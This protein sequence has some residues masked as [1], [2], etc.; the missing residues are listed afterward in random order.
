MT[1]ESAI[2]DGAVTTGRDGKS[3]I[4][5]ANFNGGSTALTGTAEAGDTVSVSLNGGTA[6]AAAVASDGTWSL[7]LNGLTDG[8]AYSA[9]A[10][11]TDAAGNTAQS[12]AFGFTVDT[13]TSESAISDSA[14]TTGTDGKSYINA[15]NF[16]NGSTTL[17]GQAEAGDTVSVSVNGGAAQAATV[18]A[19]GAWSLFLAGL[20][21]D[22]HEFYGA[23]ATAT[24]P[25][26]NTATSA[27]FGFAL[28]T[29]TSESAIADGAVTRPGRD[30]KS[31]INGA[32]FNGGSTALTGTAEAGDTVSVSLSGGTAQA[33]AVASDGTWSLTL[34]GLTDGTAYSAV[35]TATDA[36]GNTA[37]SPAF[38]FTVDTTTSESAIADFG[39]VTTGTDGKSYLNAAN[40]NGGT[41]FLTGQMEPG[42]IATVSVNINGSPSFVPATGTVQG[43]WQATLTG[44][45]DGESVSAVATASDV[46]GNTASSAPLTFTVDTTTS[47]SAIADGAVT[48]GRDGKSYINGANFNGGS[49]ALTGMAEAGDTVSVSLNG[50][51]AQAAAAW[52]RTEPGSLTLNGLTD[53]TAYSRR[54]PPARLTRPA[55]RR[56]ARPSASPSTRRRARARSPTLAR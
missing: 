7:T 18:A 50:G 36:A 40:F 13:T 15:A 1:S 5:G 20:L 19:N 42:D 12:P 2:A 44:L 11:A 45:V 43:T 8:T 49:T 26:G 6:Q 4:N 27:P 52:L 23:V 28:D 35:A 33:A 22:G 47:E 53:G 48:T 3:Y 21:R 14:V 32:N 41:I 39:A 31:Y 17:T 51:T 34:N 55:T 16:N 54:S 38:G 24:D 10:T 29:L 37:Q 25:A 9:V 30:G 56:R 46:A